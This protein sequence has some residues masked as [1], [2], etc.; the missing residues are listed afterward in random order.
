VWDSE[1]VVTVTRNSAKNTE[2]NSFPVFHGA[3]RLL[4]LIGALYQRP[5]FG[6]RPRKLRET[7][8]EWGDIVPRP[9]R[10]RKGLPMVCLV[11]PDGPENL[12]WPKL[13]KVDL[14]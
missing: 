14:E 9:E 12:L 10:S 6:D 7:D 1:R 11:R 4:K 3:D 5:R 2:R 8:G 13:N